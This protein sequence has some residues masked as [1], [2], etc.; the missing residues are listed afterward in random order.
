LC[1]KLLFG[2]GTGVVIARILIFTLRWEA[3]VWDKEGHDLSAIER[4][5]LA[6]EWRAGLR[7][8]GED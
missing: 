8:D 1:R 3:Q 7:R 4:L 6:G 2:L 5:T